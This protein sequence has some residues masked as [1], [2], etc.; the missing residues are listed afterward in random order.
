MP[1]TAATA[2]SSRRPMPSSDKSS[3]ARFLSHQRTQGEWYTRMAVE[4]GFSFNQ[5]ATSEFLSL[6]FRN[7]GMKALKSRSWI[8]ASVNSFISGLQQEVKARLKEDFQSGK[9]CSVVIDEWTSIRNHRFLN[10]C[11]VTDLDC[12]NLGLARCRGSMTAQKTA[13]LLF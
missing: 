9:R 13:D 8:S 6:G 12:T 10:V 5:M 11:I 2:H 1:Q 7:L 3:M 4:N